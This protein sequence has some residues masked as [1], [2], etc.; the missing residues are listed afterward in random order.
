MQPC[1]H[2]GLNAM[3]DA[4][5]GFSLPPSLF[6]S[7]HPR[8]PLISGA[9]RGEAESPALSHQAEVSSVIAIKQTVH[10]TN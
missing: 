9:E 1:T 3:H 2:T 7:V 4:S 6:S 10:T 8:H 5:F